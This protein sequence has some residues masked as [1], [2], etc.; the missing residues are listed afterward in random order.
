MFVARA[1]TVGNYHAKPGGATPNANCIKMNTIGDVSFTPATSFAERV[2]P[3]I[4]ASDK[5]YSF[6]RKYEMMM[7]IVN[8]TMAAKLDPV[9]RSSGLNRFLIVCRNDVFCLDCIF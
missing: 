7:G 4:A 6:C 5:M 3:Q 9:V 1:E 8:L 2:C